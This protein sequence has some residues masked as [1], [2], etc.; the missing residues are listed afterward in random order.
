[1]QPQSIPNPPPQCSVFEPVTQ[2]IHHV[3]GIQAP[4]LNRCGGNVA[5]TSKS[6]QDDTSVTRFLPETAEV[7]VDVPNIAALPQ[8]FADVQLG[9]EV[10]DRRPPAA[11]QKTPA[12]LPTVPTSPPPWRNEPVSIEIIPSRNMEEAH[13]DVPILVRVQTPKVAERVP[14]AFCCVIDVSGSMAAEA[15]ITGASGTHERH[16]LSLLDVAKHGVR[17]IIN[18]LTDKDR[19]ALI[20]FNHAAVR[21][22]G[23]TVMDE[24]GRTL[25]GNHLDQLRAGGGTNLWLGL[26]EGLEALRTDQIP[27][28]LAHVMLLTDGESNFREA[29]MP[30]LLNYEAQYERLPSTINTFGFGYQIDS[31]LLNK[32][33]AVGNGSYAFIPD[34]GFIG[35]VFVNSM[36]NLLVTFA[37][38]VTLTLQPEEDAEVLEVLGGY[39]VQKQSWGM[40]VKLG[41]LQYQ[42]TREVVIRMSSKA[43]GS[44][45]FAS[46][47]HEALDRTG[48]CVEKFEACEGVNNAD[49]KEVLPHMMRCK[50]V[51]AIGKVLPLPVKTRGF[52]DMEHKASNPSTP[53]SRSQSRKHSLTSLFSRSSKASNK[54][55][56]SRTRSDS[57][58]SLTSVE[59][60]LGPGSADAEEDVEATAAH[61]EIIDELVAEIRS[62]AVAEDNYVK[63][64][65]EDLSGQVCEA[66]SCKAFYTKW[67]CHYLPSI[68]F[69]H[70]LQQ[71]NNFKDPGVQCYGGEL[72]AELRDAADDIFC[73][74]PPPKPSAVLR[75]CSQMSASSAPRTPLGTGPTSMA[76][77]NDRY[78]GCI[79]GRCL[80]ALANGKECR[81]D[82]VAK[83]DKVLTLQGEVATVV[84]VVRSPC[85]QGVASLVSIAGQCGTLRLTPHHPVLVDGSWVFPADVA[86]PQD[87][88]CDAVYSFLLSGGSAM[89]VAGIPCV[90]LGHGIQEGAAAHPYLGSQSLVTKDLCHFPGFSHGLVELEPKSVCRDSA[91]GLICRLCP[92]V[93]A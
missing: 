90:A 1:M 49:E 67:G 43:G 29:I 34:A 13:D 11:V 4:A 62:S 9:E 26:Q 65:L 78:A 5:C 35:T 58:G 52:R 61:K 45:L 44:Y 47:Q 19:L 74:L 18:T 32:L 17:T 38:E 60:G 22:L 3:F 36:S 92:M 16:G 85:A 15:T 82:E 12:P 89:M 79:D 76:A 37:R 33:A 83:G 71:C 59:S 8:V 6:E 40:S 27:G 70:K 7:Q 81:I 51:D 28:S 57:V 25:A 39:E 73:K 55:G 42:Q 88:V 50:L 21:V 69:A 66:V 93:D 91:T 87:L 86:S 14:S 63:A 10:E 77:Y 41:T 80:V 64:L 48:A 24:A 54:T 53:K 30:N 72:F 84:C 2:F 20:S 56:N 23:L 46:G 31:G 68:M 75:A